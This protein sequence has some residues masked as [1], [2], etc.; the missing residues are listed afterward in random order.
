MKVSRE[1]VPFWI[2]AKQQELETVKFIY[3]CALPSWETA[4]AWGFIKYERQKLNE[5][6]AKHLHFLM[7]IE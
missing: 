6:V 1:K 7:N 4:D 2:Y 3:A 5:N